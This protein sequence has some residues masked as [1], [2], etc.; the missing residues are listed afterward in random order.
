M[1]GA[2]IEER[3]RGFENGRLSPCGG[4]PDRKM[5]AMPPITRGADAIGPKLVSRASVS[6]LSFVTWRAEI[7]KD[8]A[9]VRL[10]MQ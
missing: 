8:D 9:N 7:S 4:R 2:V 1:V 10:A 3:R 5:E 6:S